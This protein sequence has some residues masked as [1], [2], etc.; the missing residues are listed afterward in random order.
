MR[1]TLI[2]KFVALVVATITMVS[3]SKSSSEID[4]V[5]FKGPDDA[6]W[7]MI[8]TDGT[9]IFQDE[10]KNCP[11]PAV[12]GRFF[13]ETS[14]GVYEMF[15]AEKK[16]KK[17][18]GEYVSVS[19]FSNGQALVTEK[20]KPIEIIDTEGKVI[21]V[22]DKIDG[23]PIE[24]AYRSH[25]DYY[26]VATDSLF[27]LVDRKGEMVLK[28][29]YYTLSLY[30]DDKFL[31]EKGDK[32]MIIDSKGKEVLSL[33][34]YETVQA[35]QDTKLLAVSLTKDGES[36]S[37]IIDE[38]GNYVVRPSAKYKRIVSIIYDKMFI[39]QSGGNNP[40]C[41]LMSIDGESLIRAKYD[42]M[43]AL[44]DELF[45][46][47]NSKD[48]KIECQ[49]VNK[50][51]EKIGDDTYQY[52]DNFHGDYAFAQ[53][54]DKEYVIVGKDGKPIKDVPDIAS[55]DVGYH[56]NS[57]DVRS[58]YVDL[59]SMVEALDIKADGLLGITTASTPLDALKKKAEYSDY[60]VTLDPNMYNYTNSVEV[61]KPVGKTQAYI[62]Y[63]F[64]GNLSDYNINF[65]TYDYSYFWNN[66]H[67][68]FFA[69]GINCGY[70]SRLNGKEHDLKNVVIDK[71]KKLG[72]AVVKQTDNGAVLR[73]KNG[74]YAV[75]QIDGEKVMAVWGKTTQEEAINSLSQSGALVRDTD[76]EYAVPCD[77][78]V[79]D[80]AWA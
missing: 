76:A 61:H 9:V 36:I 72:G 27:G 63:R 60:D 37:G 62:S 77:S 79:A 21:K 33:T 44:S 7:G 11:T 78:D 31:A 45:A 14:D 6:N 39:Y 13:V 80:S 69:F 25:N 59:E 56:Y 52:V 32:K 50:N 19:T 47:F 53:V 46:A 38:N 12:D 4:G 2:L 54:S 71:F 35:F 22:L 66:V 28:P 64:D 58:D 49:I 43:T 70:D 16:P 30:G 42:L 10:F 1:K 26:I 24:K 17:V 57:L 23:Q 55:L 29:V 34:K 48:G 41:G 18:G 73:L 74:M 65:D 40:Q 5:G 8:A 20:G 51:D 67:P 75:C 68:I 3:C 15:T